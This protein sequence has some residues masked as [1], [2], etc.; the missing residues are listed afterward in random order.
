MSLW[1]ALFG[2]D[3]TPKPLKGVIVT[4]MD[5]ND[6][7]DWMLDEIEWREHRKTQQHDG[8]CYYTD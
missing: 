4:K 8:G 3:E 5:S 2:K 6:W 7:L 1:S